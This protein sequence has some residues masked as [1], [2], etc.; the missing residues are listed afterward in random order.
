MC[1]KGEVLLDSS[2]DDSRTSVHILVGNTHLRLPN[3]YEIPLSDIICV[4]FDEKHP[5]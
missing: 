1:L 3:G 4:E 5:G 2:P